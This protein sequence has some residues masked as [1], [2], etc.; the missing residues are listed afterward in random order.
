MVVPELHRSVHTYNVCNVLDTL[1]TSFH[2]GALFPYLLPNRLIRNTVLYST[3]W[4]ERRVWSRNIAP[5]GRCFVSARSFVCFARHENCHQYTPR[6][7]LS[8]N[9]SFVL[10]SGFIY[11]RF[12]SLDNDVA[13][14]NSCPSPGHWT[15]FFTGSRSYQL[16]S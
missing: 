9:K 15:I 10:A 7:Y 8:F 2:N 13:V 4:K 6:I 11:S 16:G 5:S 14:A 12:T 3:N 1:L